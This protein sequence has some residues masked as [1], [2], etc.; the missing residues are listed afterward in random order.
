M[1]A[2]TSTATVE[3]AFIP[4]HSATA[5][6]DRAAARAGETWPRTAPASGSRIHGSIAIGRNSADVAPS[7]L[8]AI[9]DRA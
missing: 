8:S 6:A 2:G 7:M 9:G 4:L 5:T 3:A 1:S